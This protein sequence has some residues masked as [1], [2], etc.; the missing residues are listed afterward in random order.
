MSDFNAK[1]H[2]ILFPLEFTAL[3]QTFWLYLRSLLLRGGRIREREKR[4]KGRGRE[5]EG[6]R[7]GKPQYFDLDRPY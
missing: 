4:G 3:P 5:E 7:E 2:N 6:G 1:M